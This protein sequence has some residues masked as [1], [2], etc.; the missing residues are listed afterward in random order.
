MFGKDR[1]RE[2]ISA[3]ADKPARYVYAAVVNAVNEFLGAAPQLDDV[4]LVVIKA[5]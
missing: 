3:N 2:V 1:L 4:T 5:L